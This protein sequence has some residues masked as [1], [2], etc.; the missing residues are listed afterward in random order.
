MGFFDIRIIFQGSFPQRKAVI[1]LMYI[2]FNGY[3]H[4]ERIGYMNKQDVYVT[5]H[6]SRT[7]QS[8]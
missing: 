1:F 4:F 2:K 3:F 7:D 6:E 8:N 5:W